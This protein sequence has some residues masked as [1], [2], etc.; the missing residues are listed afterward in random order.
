MAAYAEESA[1]EARERA[2]VHQE[3]CTECRFVSDGDSILSFYARDH[4]DKT[5]VEPF[6]LDNF[7]MSGWVGHLPFYLFWCEKCDNLCVD[8]PHGH[9]L[10]LVYSCC[11]DRL[12]ISDP[13]IYE[14]LD[15]PRPPTEWEAFV[16]LF[17]YLWRTRNNGGAKSLDLH[18]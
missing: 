2:R 11:G 17:K 7:Y 12:Q 3:N 6:F 1:E 15:M 4:R 10:F 5:Y 9:V 16:A 14:K 18:S 8:Y 13:E